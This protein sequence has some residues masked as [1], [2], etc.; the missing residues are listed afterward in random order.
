MSELI[1]GIFPGEILPTKTVGGCI[2]IFESIWPD[3]ERT[4]ETIENLNKDPNSGIGWEA[5][6]TL[7]LGTDQQV[8]TNLML[9]VTNL[10]EITNN[11]ALQN[12]HN[13]FYMLLL[14]SSIPYTDRYSLGEPL[15]H[16][17]YNMLRYSGGQQYHAHYDG[18]TVTGRAISAICYLNEDYTG[19]ELEFPNFNVKIKPKKGSLLLFPSNYAYSHVAHPVTEGQKYALV[20]WIRDRYID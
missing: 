11:G 17:N 18:S 8:R 6:T 3:P 15:Y 14:A 10:A 5:A 1:N 13:Q 4:I 7:N 19:G 16:E 9:G 20:T 2:D 12:I